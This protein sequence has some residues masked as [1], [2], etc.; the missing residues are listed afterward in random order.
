MLALKVTVSASAILALRF[1]EF[2]SLHPDFWIKLGVVGVSFK[3]THMIARQFGLSE[4]HVGGF[5]AGQ[6]C[7]FDSGGAKP[8]TGDRDA[9]TG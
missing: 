3:V 5:K 2:T 7:G 8:I 9:A 4:K 1:I 6:I